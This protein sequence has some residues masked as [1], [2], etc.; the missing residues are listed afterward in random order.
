MTTRPSAPI[1]GFSV[2]VGEFLEGM[3]EDAGVEVGD[4]CIQS[5]LSGRPVQAFSSIVCQSVS[6]EE[7]QYRVHK[8]HFILLYNIYFLLIWRMYSWGYGG[9]CAWPLWGRHAAALF[10][11]RNFPAFGIGNMKRILGDTGGQRF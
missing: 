10:G 8:I 5:R 6:K 11:E 4:G 3:T 1:S 7:C 9:L 2:T